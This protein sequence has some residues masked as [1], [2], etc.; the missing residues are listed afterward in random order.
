[1]SHQPV[2]GFGGTA[3]G[4]TQ[5]RAR[6]GATWLRI[7]LPALVALWAL[8][9]CSE[10]HITA[11]PAARAKSASIQAADPPGR[12]LHVV[13]YTDSGLWH[14]MRREDLGWFDAPLY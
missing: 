10:D 1:M 3:S 11:A 2:V 4:R 13:G 5:Q 6:S 8:L 14:L 7:H 12:V 9:G